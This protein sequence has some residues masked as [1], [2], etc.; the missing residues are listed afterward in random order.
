MA[1]RTTLKGYF[2]K[3]DKPTEA[4]FAQLI[5][6]LLN[7]DDDP[8]NI[9]T[10]LL[11]TLEADDGTNESILTMLAG[12]NSSATLKT[13]NVTK[14][15]YVGSSI[16][17][18]NVLSVI[19]VNDGSTEYFVRVDETEILLDFDGVQLS[20]SADGI[21]ANKRTYQVESSISYA[22][23]VAVDL[24]TKDNF[25]IGQVT[26]NLTINASNIQNGQQGYIYFTIDS[27]GGYSMALGSGTWQA[28][29]NS[30]DI[31][32]ANVA[33]TEYF[34]FFLVRNNTI[35]YNINSISP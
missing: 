14:N 10:N 23:A 3:F 31:A 13:S 2:E 17:A 29:D 18:G 1:D 5:D 24:Q 25:A 15:G 9:I 27:T 12:A 30:I 33:D 19:Y 20:I 22:A 16:L 6:S 7:L 11:T 26:G 32:A 35:Y 8:I 21:T 28:F 4:Q 34:L